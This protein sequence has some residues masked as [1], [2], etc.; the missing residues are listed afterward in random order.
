MKK[1]ADPKP[2]AS[3]NPWLTREIPEGFALLKTDE[4]GLL[5]HWSDWRIV[6]LN[7]VPFP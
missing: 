6:P 7:A 4:E 5:L 2:S 1:R 3:L